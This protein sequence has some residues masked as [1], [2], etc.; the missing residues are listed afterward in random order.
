MAMDYVNGTTED[1]YAEVR[2]VFAE[3]VTEDW[4]A[5]LA[6]Y[7]EGRLVVDLWTTASAGPDTLTGV[8]S[9]TKGAA[10][11]VI[12]RL[13]Q[14]RV[15]DLD[16]RVTTWWPEFAGD[17]KDDLTLRDLLAHRS[18]L[19]GVDGGFHTVELADDRILADRLVR[20]KPFW[21][22][23]HAYGYHAFVIGALLGAVAERATGH[24]VQELFH[25][26]IRTP[27]AVDVF[28]GDPSFTTDTPAPPTGGDT[29]AASTTPSADATPV[30]ARTTPTA[31]GTPAARY[32]P[33][34]PASQKP[35]IAPLS[36]TGIAFNLNADPPTDLVEW[37]DIPAVRALGQSSAGG[38]ASARGLAR[39]YAAALWGA[40]GADPLLDRATI[41]QFAAV[42]S[43]G[44][45]RVTGEDSHFGLGFEAQHPRYPGLSGSA[46]GHSGAAGTHALADP[47]HGITYA[48]TR[49][50]F[51]FPGGAAGENAD[52]IN[53]V[54]RTLTR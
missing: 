2:D 15:L 50:R 22:P 20:Q 8:F 38:V 7:V 36:L 46:F 32:L 9:A 19:I 6:V 52:L 4:A 24:T 5:Q 26:L 34:L 39:M 11:L 33:V 41:D 40:D 51:G 16:R 44:S 54:L 18:G 37:I 14:D 21:K 30:A 27:Y 47:S 35:D 49:R 10:H 42:S 17:G 3:V 25:S 53:A 12:A 43:A 29:A 31:G 28:L 48:Y 1:A 23:G 45:D 13:V